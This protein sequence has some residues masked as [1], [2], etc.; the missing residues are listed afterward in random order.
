LTFRAVIKIVVFTVLACIGFFVLFGI[1][2]IYISALT[3]NI[4]LSL[5]LG[6][7]ISAITIFALITVL[8]P[9]RRRI[10][11]VLSKRQT[12]GVYVV[13]AII[14]VSSLPLIKIDPLLFLGYLP[15]LV[16][17]TSGVIYETLRGRNGK[18]HKKL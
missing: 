8:I 1:S 5:L 10:R 11:L 9:P 18:L 17:V 15:T 6:L 3:L 12:V 16:A 14:F 2:F 7:F 13:W 4:G